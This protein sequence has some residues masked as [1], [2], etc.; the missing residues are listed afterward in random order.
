M[1]LPLVCEQPGISNIY[2]TSSSG[3][4]GA[5]DERTGMCDWASPASVTLGFISCDLARDFGIVR[6]Q[7]APD[8]APGMARMCNEDIDMSDVTCDAFITTDVEGYSWK[9]FALH[10]DTAETLGYENRFRCGVRRAGRA[11]SL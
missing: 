6:R 8:S 11:A 9:W 4:F 7:L 10:N 2:Q 5:V 1:G 3:F